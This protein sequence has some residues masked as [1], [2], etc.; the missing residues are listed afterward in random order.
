MTGSCCV[1]QSGVVWPRP[2]HESAVASLPRSHVETPSDAS[3]FSQDDELMLLQ[4]LSAWHAL[5]IPAGE[6]ILISDHDALC[7]VSVSFHG[8]Q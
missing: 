1:Q 7:G 3:T 8:L 6:Q 4:H 5:D 2:R